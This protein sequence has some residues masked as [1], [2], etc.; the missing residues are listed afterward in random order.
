MT[1]EQMLTEIREA[2]LAYLM[3]AKSLLRGDRADALY[4]LGIGDQVADMIDTLTPAQMMKIASG[5]TLL[6]RMRFDDDIVWNLLTDHGRGVGGG[7]HHL[8]ATIVQAG[9]HR[10]ASETG[11][12]VL[13]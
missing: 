9:R 5:N 3:L 2:N 12:A 7:L 1:N 4:R 8:H 11:L 6:C 10:E 13:S